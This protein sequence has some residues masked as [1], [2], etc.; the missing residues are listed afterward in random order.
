MGSFARWWPKTGPRQTVLAAGFVVL[1]SILPILWEVLYGVGLRALSSSPKSVCLMLLGLGLLQGWRRARRAVRD[2]LAVVLPV[3]AIVSTVVIGYGLKQ[4]RLD[5]VAF[6][7]GS[8]I[9][10]LAGFA[11]LVSDA[12]WEYVERPPN[13]WG[14]GWGEAAEPTGSPAALP[15]EQAMLPAERVEVVMAGAGRAIAK[16][17]G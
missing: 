1:G 8:T 16:D 6:A 3:A 2:L 4:T 17:R 7:A 13:R 15:A 12:A 14:S 9:A 11:L 10:F 5:V